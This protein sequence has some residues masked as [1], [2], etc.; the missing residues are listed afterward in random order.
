MLAEVCT[1]TP[2]RGSIGSR[3]VVR[4]LSQP[5]CASHPR[6]VS[7]PVSWTSLECSRLPEKFAGSPAVYSRRA[8]LREPAESRP[9]APRE[10][11]REACLA[12]SMCEEPVPRE[13]CKSPTKSPWSQRIPDCPATEACGEVSVANWLSESARMVQTSVAVGWGRSK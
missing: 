9:P 8:H 4:V 12:M 3:G 6:L 5:F 1:T 13:A 2:I 10:A 11:R 7:R